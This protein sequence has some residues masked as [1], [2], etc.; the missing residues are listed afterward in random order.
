MNHSSSVQSSLQKKKKIERLF[1]T[2]YELTRT[3][4]ELTVQNQISWKML[5]ILHKLYMYRRVNQVTSRNQSRR[6]NDFKRLPFM[7]SAKLVDLKFIITTTV[8]LENDV[9]CQQFI[10]L[11]LDLGTIRRELSGTSKFEFSRIYLI[12]RLH[13]VFCGIWFVLHVGKI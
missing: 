5:L 8:S 3:S 1:D 12:S 13:I 7:Q 4:R 6:G 2:V 11:A 9:S 10:L